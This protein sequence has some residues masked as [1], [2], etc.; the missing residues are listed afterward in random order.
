MDGS[1]AGEVAPEQ[2]TKKS[3]GK[4]KKATGKAAPKAAPK[5]G[6]KSKGKGKKPSSAAGE[7]AATQAA[8][9]SKGKGKKES[10]QAEVKAPKQPVTK[11]TAQP[12]AQPAA[13]PT[14]QPAALAVQGATKKESPGRARD[15]M[16]SRKFWSLF[17]AHELHPVAMEAFKEI[18]TMKDVKDSGYREKMTELITTTFK[19][20]EANK[21][22]YDMTGPLYTE[23]RTRIQSGYRD[24]GVDGD[25]KQ[26][27]KTKH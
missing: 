17:E 16:K 18:E 15:L 3:K 2:A 20:D 11:P 4:G 8:T 5:K 1:Q 6:A 19:R 27:K 21:L 25:H 10:S 7:T 13:P 9:K 14:A 26:N 23:T 22:V 12:A 24:G